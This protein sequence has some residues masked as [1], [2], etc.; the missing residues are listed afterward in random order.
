MGVIDRK[1]LAKIVIA[2]NPIP[3]FANVLELMG[4]LVKSTVNDVCQYR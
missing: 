1:P 3:I 2:V 4:F